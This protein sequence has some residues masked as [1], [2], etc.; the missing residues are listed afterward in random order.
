MEVSRRFFAA[1]LAALV[2]SPFM[3]IQSA[4]EKR[5]KLK[6]FSYESNGNPI[7]II[8]GTAQQ[9]RNAFNSDRFGGLIPDLSYLDNVVYSI[10]NTLSSNPLY[11]ASEFN[12][13]HE[14]Y[15][16]RDKLTDMRFIKGVKFSSPNT[17]IRLQM[18]GILNAE[19]QVEITKLAGYEI[20]DGY[21]DNE[22]YGALRLVSPGAEEW[23]LAGPNVEEGPR[24]FTSA[25]L[26]SAL[27]GDFN[28]DIIELDIAGISQPLS[29]GVKYQKIFLDEKL[30]LVR[31]QFDEKGNLLPP[32][33]K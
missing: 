8:E 28:L 16:N 24:R 32:Y 21:T 2:A 30:K 15:G 14:G 11:L 26:Q 19:R 7:K 9:L 22:G 3:P 5:Y 1:N 23:N 13:M 27:E 4:G 18:N 31:P 12:L 29:D 20:N 33:A 17:T 25:R 10:A 6:L